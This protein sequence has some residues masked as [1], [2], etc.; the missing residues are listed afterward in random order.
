MHA[1]SEGFD[2]LS[3]IRVGDLPMVQSSKR[4]DGIVSRVQSIIEQHPDPQARE[5]LSVMEALAGA[6]KARDRGAT[7]L[8]VFG[9]LKELI[10][11]RP[12]S[13]HLHSEGFRASFV[14]FV[15]FFPPNSKRPI[16]CCRAS[17]NGRLPTSLHRHR[18]VGPF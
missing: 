16:S 5:D 11:E 7:E 3:G 8:L 13:A 6:S 2:L 12:S 14:S 17:G 18:T 1:T 15:S 10:G 9:D 4:P